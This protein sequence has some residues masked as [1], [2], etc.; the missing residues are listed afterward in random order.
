[1]K[2]KRT[3]LYLLLFFSSSWVFGQSDGFQSS[4]NNGFGLKIGA[5][6]NIWKSDHLTTKSVFSPGIELGATFGVTENIGI[7]ATYQSI[8]Q[9]K[10]S[11]NEVDYLVYTHR[12]KH[13]N[14]L[15]GAHYVMG[16][17]SSKWR[18][19]I[20]AGIHIPTSQ[21]QIFFDLSDAYSDLRLKGTGL[22]AGAGISYFL[23]PFISIDMGIA[24]MSGKYH[25]SE[26]L[27]IAHK[28][29]VK[30]TMPQISVGLQYHFNGR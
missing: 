23:A 2:K 9:G 19:K 21:V 6:G 26:F 11:E 4:V 15:L 12:A 1:M 5:V 16:S 8:G 25:Q 10:T 29:S 7:F 18:Y 27:G 28:E 24:W 17:T 14:I 3:L 13:Q 22:T 30:Y 20:Q